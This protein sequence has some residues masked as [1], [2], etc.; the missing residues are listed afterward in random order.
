[1]KQLN[2][3]SPFRWNP[4]PPPNHYHEMEFYHHRSRRFYRMRNLSPGVR[5]DQLRI[6]CICEVALLRQAHYLRRNAPFLSIEYVK[7]GSLLVRQRECACELE[8][9]EVFLMQPQLE[10]EFLSGEGG[11]RK[12]SLMVSGMLLIPFLQG[13]GL[14]E[15]DI[16]TGL[17]SRCMERVL[18]E[19]GEL[20]DE[21]PDVG[22]IRNTLLC[23]EILQLLRGRP[24]IVSFPPAL[25]E[26]RISLEQHPEYAWTQSE[27]AQYCN[28]SPTHLVRLFHC[29]FHTTPRQ[30]LLDLRI[31]RAR[32]LLADET[33]SIKEIAAA[34]GFG[35]ALNFS[36]CFRHRQG[37]SPREYRKQLTYF[38]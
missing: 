23:F 8:P 19:I 15:K 11:C 1:M 28:C 31:H 13:S 22:S 26:L 29:Y 24:D 34:V 4:L 20:A 35:N 16:V 17:D 37:M 18:Q 36:T 2:D 25:A 32:R 7:S 12:I 27:M 21:T 3:L 14:G 6:E 30:Y 38:S 10:S 5:E 9:G 33:Y